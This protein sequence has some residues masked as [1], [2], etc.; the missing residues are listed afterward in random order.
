MALIVLVVVALVLVR[1]PA[2]VRELSRKLRQY[3]FPEGPRELSV[4]LLGELRSEMARSSATGV[5]ARVEA[6]NSIRGWSGNEQAEF[7]M[8]ALSSQFTELGIRTLSAK[9]AF[10]PLKA[11]FSNEADGWCSAA[12]VSVSDCVAFRVD[13]AG[14]R[15]EVVIVTNRAYRLLRASNLAQLGVEG[16][17]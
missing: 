17:L 16:N 7:I 9:A 11:V 13:G 14:F 4:K 5:L 3:M 12:G 6:P 2:P 1:P 10:G 15:T 8:K